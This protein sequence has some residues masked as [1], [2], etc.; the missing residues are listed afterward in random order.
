MKIECPN[1]TSY[2]DTVIKQPRVVVYSLYKGGGSCKRYGFFFKND[3]DNIKTTTLSD[4]SKSGFDRGHLANAEDFA[5]D[6]VLEEYTFRYYNCIPQTRILNRGVW[7]EKE[8]TVREL[9][10]TDTIRI[11][12]F[13]RKFRKYGTLYVPL[14]CGKI[15]V[16]K[17]G[18]V[19]MWTFDQNGYLLN[20]SS[21]VRRKYLKYLK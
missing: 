20:N 9:S 16:K 5:F 12:C 13:A 2:F 6:C 4:Y 7:R 1:Y 11:V 14:I 3:K 8:I 15:V 19:F 10:Q 21:V 17:D 18:T